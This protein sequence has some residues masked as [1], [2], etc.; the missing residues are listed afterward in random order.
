MYLTKSQQRKIDKEQNRKKI[1]DI[2]T[3]VKEILGKEKSITKNKFTIEKFGIDDYIKFY[4]HY[5]DEFLDEIITGYKL[6]FEDNIIL[7]GDVQYYS[8]DEWLE[9]Q[10]CH[11]VKNNHQLDIN[12]IY[13]KIFINFG[14][15]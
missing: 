15:G 7:V 2:L 14:N 10:T 6:E 8:D 3:L 5:D 13:N 9:C 12:M 11:E 4:D 1:S